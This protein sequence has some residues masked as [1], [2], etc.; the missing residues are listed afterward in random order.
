MTRS[1]PASADVTKFLA[2]LHRYK[3]NMDIL[4]ILNVPWRK[5]NQINLDSWCIH[6]VSYCRYRHIEEEARPFPLR[7]P[8][9]EA[10]GKPGISARLPSRRSHSSSSKYWS[11]ARP[12]KVDGS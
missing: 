6:V 12:S 9:C 5:T 7:E 2:A 4:D 8:D 3:C 10:N 11:I 1:V